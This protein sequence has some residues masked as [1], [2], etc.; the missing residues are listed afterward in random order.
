MGQ[1]TRNEDAGFESDS[2][3][4]I[5]MSPGNSYFKD[6]EVRYLLEKTVKKFGKTAILVADIPAITTYRALGYS[7]SKARAKAVLKGNNLKNRTRKIQKELKLPAEAVRIIEWSVDVAPNSEYQKIYGR[8]EGLYKRSSSF[9]EAVNQ[10]TQSVFEHSDKEVKNMREAVKEGVHYLLSELAFLEFAPTFLES[11]HV[12]YVYHKNWPVYED[13]VSGKFDGK[14]KLYL[15]F[16]LLE[17]P[18]ETY[19]PLAAKTE[20][21]SLP[22]GTYE[23]ILRTKEIRG[24]FSNYPPTFMSEKGKV[25]GIFYELIKSFAD[26]LG[27]TLK[28]TEETGYGVIVEGLNEGRFDLFCSAVW[29][30]PERL[31]QADFSIPLYYSDAYLWI[32]KSDLRF[33]NIKEIDN[34][35]FRIAIKEGD[36]SDSIARADFPKSRYVRVPQLSETVELLRFVAED[37]ADATFVET[38]LAEQFN[39]TARTKLISIGKPLR[40]YP[41]TFMIRK[42]EKKLKVALDQFLQGAIQSGLLEKLIK[43]YSGKT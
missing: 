22:E 27:A 7:E 3:P 23:R 43:K 40:N 26:G 1:A 11:K 12:I 17:N 41:N 8:I 28:L 6:G 19:K 14:P 39:K 25:T 33:K 18:A 42:G 10:T 2:Y 31:A 38:Y 29:P 32:R 35:F 20:R 9:M 36:I 30:T 34:P 15:D 16:L 4:I 13:Y 21:Q 24:A 5:G 37:K